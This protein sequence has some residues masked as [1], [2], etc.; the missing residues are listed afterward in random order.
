MRRISAAAE[1]GSCFLQ[2][3]W[4]RFWTCASTVR[5]KVATVRV[6]DRLFRLARDSVTC[7][8]DLRAKA[9]DPLA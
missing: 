9:I 3:F 4:T 8:I 1:V 7:K 2:S 6:A 5:V